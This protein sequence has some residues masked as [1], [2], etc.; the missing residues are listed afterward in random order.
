MDIRYEQ[1]LCG[2]VLQ[3]FR[4]LS[5][6]DTV[7]GT[8]VKITSGVLAAVAADDRYPLGFV[9]ET[10][11]VSETSDDHVQVIP[12]MPGHVYSIPVISTEAVGDFLAISGAD[13]MNV[14][15]ANSFAMVW[16]NGGDTTRTYFVVTTAS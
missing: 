14:D 10:K 12:F 8:L 3:G 5:G 1:P 13:A 7:P 2:G 15:A 6:I 11:D 9:T 4:F 16:P